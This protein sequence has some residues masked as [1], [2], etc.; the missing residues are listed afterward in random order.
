MAAIRGS[1]GALIIGISISLS[2]RMK[3]IKIKI[4]EINFYFYLW[5][6][7][8]GGQSVGGTGPARR[9][10]AGGAAAD[11]AGAARAGRAAA[12]AAAGCAGPLVGPHPPSPM[13][14]TAPPATLVGNFGRSADLQF[15][16]RGRAHARPRPGRNSAAG[17][18]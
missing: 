7:S 4:H 16:R 1:T 8:C 11:A 18:A 15:P 3:E 9:G 12:G 5:I 17:C 14:A 6:G 13:G 10:G 2:D